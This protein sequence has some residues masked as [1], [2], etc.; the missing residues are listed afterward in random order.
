MGAAFPAAIVEGAVSRPA[1]KAIIA[2][3]PGALSRIEGIVHPL[4][5]ADRAAFLAA[6]TAP[7]VLFD[8]PLLFETGAD[9]WLD[10][11]VV[12]SAPAEAQRARVLA[13]PG[14]TEGDLDRILA[15]Q[16]PDAEKRARAD[17][18]IDTST[19]ETAADGVARV[20]ADVRRRVGLTDKG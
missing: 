3:D 5:A 4:V 13:R 1:L 6:A 16:M 19:L 11:T 17:Y 8:I 18:V 15:R 2:A 20:L 12:V 9:K 7:I 14:M 10:A